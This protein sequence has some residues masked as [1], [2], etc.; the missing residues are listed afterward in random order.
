MPNAKKPPEGIRLRHAKGC[1][2]RGQGACNCN[3]SYEA[4]VPLG[5]RGRRTRKTFANLQEAK[6]WRARG[7]VAVADGLLRASPSTTLREAA[8]DL[9]DGMERG[10]VRTRSGDLYKPSV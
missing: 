7:V 2:A 5:G 1:P 6:A 4:T 10:S 9:V 8:E 3:P